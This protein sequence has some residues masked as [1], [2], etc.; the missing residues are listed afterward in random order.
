MQI[1]FLAVLFMISRIS[2]Y[3]QEYRS[4]F[5]EEFRKMKNIEA[6]LPAPSDLGGSSVYNNK[7]EQQKCG[8]K[9]AR[10]TA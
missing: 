6:L 8:K 4:G 10:K 7:I 9:Q 1:I 5:N 3:R 2:R